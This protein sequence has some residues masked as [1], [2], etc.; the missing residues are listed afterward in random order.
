[1]L[2]TMIGAHVKNTEYIGSISSL[3]S[4]IFLCWYNFESFELAEIRMVF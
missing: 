2:L 4:V 1:M 3:R